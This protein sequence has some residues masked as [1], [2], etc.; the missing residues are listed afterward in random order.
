MYLQLSNYLLYVFLLTVIYYVQIFLE[1]L[2][3]LKLSTKK[4]KNTDDEKKKNK[5]K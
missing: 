3:Q 1:K 4:V 2:Q 5:Y